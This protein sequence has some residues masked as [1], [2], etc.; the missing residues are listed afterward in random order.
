LWRVYLVVR[1]MH[2][3][4]HISMPNM[5]HDHEQDCESVLSITEVMDSK[6]DA[7]S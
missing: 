5:K 6:L 2:I 4:L 3:G 7:T 1:Q